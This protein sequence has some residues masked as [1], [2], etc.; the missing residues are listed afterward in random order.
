VNIERLMSVSD[1]PTIPNGPDGTTPDDGPEGTF[2]QMLNTRVSEMSEQNNPAANIST[3]SH[4]ADWLR[5]LM[6]I[7]EQHTD[8]D[9]P[10]LDPAG[11]VPLPTQNEMTMSLTEVMAALQSLVSQDIVTSLT[12]QVV[13]LH[14][15]P[16][17]EMVGQKPEVTASDVASSAK[18]GTA[19]FAQS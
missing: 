11:E 18:N 15:K 4:K 16:S 3:T 6:D 2:N 17:S 10:V 5:T 19:S 9:I 12:Q 8:G 1:Q 14:P 7:F 13:E